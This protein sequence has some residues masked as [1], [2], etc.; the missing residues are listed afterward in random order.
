M[1]GFIHRGEIRGGGGKEYKRRGRETETET[2]REKE[3]GR[4][5]K[6]GLLTGI[7][8]IDSDGKTHR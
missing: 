7:K 2:E 1:V 5:R 4:E 6:R 8:E 3:R